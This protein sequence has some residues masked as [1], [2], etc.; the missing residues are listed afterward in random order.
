MDNVWAPNQLENF[1]RPS[2]RTCRMLVSELKTAVS[3]VLTG[4]ADHGKARSF[5]ETPILDYLDA[6]GSSLR[7][8]KSRSIFYLFEKLYGAHEQMPN[9]KL[10]R[11][12]TLCDLFLQI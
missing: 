6:N 8:I 9:D 10:T 11:L 1:D 5:G 4:E 3:D 2:E 7:Q 12:L